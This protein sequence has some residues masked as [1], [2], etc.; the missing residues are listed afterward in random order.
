LTVNSGACGTFS[1]GFAEA[2]LG[3][4]DAGVLFRLSFTKASIKSRFIN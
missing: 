1:L 4:K 3:V 2:E